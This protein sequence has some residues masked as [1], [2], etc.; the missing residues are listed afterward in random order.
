MPA[1]EPLVTSHKRKFHRTAAQL[2]PIIDGFAVKRLLKFRGTIYGILVIITYFT[3][4]L[5]GFDI[6]YDLLL[7]V[8]LIATLYIGYIV[9]LHD[10]DSL[11]YYII[12][13]KRAHY[14]TLVPTPINDL[15]DKKVM[16]DSLPYKLLLAIFVISLF[17][18]FLTFITVNLDFGGSSANLG[19]LGTLKFLGSGILENFREN[20]QRLHKVLH[21]GVGITIMLF[22]THIISTLSFQRLTNLIDIIDEN[23]THTED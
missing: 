16:S 15:I 20:H 3:F 7:I 21:F 4:S 18:I 6:Y 22:A 9:L 19:V 8:E 10:C 13:K 5:C 2:I 17:G 14:P 23:K 11:Y 1:R 12:L